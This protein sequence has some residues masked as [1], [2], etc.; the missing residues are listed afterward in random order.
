MSDPPPV[1]VAI[2][3]LKLD[4]KTQK[5]NQCAYLGPCFSLAK[6][7]FAITGI[8]SGCM[9]GPKIAARLTQSGLKFSARVEFQPR[10]M[11]EPLINGICSESWT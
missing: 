4:E 11:C 1:F 8:F 6:N 9:T 7:L 10:L 2:T 5:C 3:Y